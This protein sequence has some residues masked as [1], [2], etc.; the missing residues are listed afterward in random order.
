MS[1]HVDGTFCYYTYNNVCLYIYPNACFQASIL[2]TQYHIN[3]YKISKLNIN[4]SK[5][6]I[7]L[8]FV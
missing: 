6:K 3:G 7:K 2:S 5:I 4:G 1:R 8:N